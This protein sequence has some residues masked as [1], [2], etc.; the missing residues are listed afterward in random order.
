MFKKI[1]GLLI[2][3]L[4]ILV[5]LVALDQGPLISIQSF[6]LGLV[7]LITIV[8]ISSS[9]AKK[10]HLVDI[11]DE[12]RKDH[13][14]KIPLVGGIG[15]FI[16]LIYGA[17]VFGV[18]PFYLYLLGSL[19]PIM[20]MGI[21]DGIQRINDLTAFRKILPVLRIIAQVIASWIVILSTDIY[22]KNLGDIFGAGSI[23]LGEL[24]IPFTIFAV[25]GMCNAFNMIDGKDG[26][27]GSTTVITLF[28]LLLLLYINDVIFLW[29]QI[30][31]FSI[32]VYL[33]FNLSL[34]GKNRKIFLGD[35]GSNG[36]GHIIAW[37][38]I[39]L[40]QDTEFLTPVSALWFVLLPLTD[41]LL[42]FVRR[43][44]SSSSIFKADR[45]HFHHKLADMGIND[46]NI[47][48]I[49]CSI[50][51]I[52]CAIAIAANLLPIEESI[53]FY[54]Y[55]TLIIFCSLLGFSKT[56]KNKDF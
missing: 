51:V 25:A 40:S 22:L 53:M 33:A 13:K 4:Y 44:R 41:A 36:L 30:L 5:L 45:Q 48:F 3:T 7:G 42:T 52:S 9:F 15:L 46:R 6:A 55:I 43:Y 11:S 29:G 27:L 35:H 32:L 26:L 10:I 34:F 31:I 14:G 2:L 12:P 28:S 24:G 17:T 21:I 38:L 39:Y 18:D 50:S 56:E 37:S 23:Y 1:L 54:G 16:S 20:I 19:I 47:L 49:F 8:I